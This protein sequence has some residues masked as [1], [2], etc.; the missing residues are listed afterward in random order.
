MSDLRSRPQG[1]IAGPD[2]R[3]GR[4]PLALDP[5]SESVLRGISDLPEAGAAHTARPGAEP[6]ALHAAARAGQ[7]QG[8]VFDDAPT[9]SAPEEPAFASDPGRWRVD[10]HARDAEDDAHYSF[11][12][13]PRFDTEPPRSEAPRPERPL[14]DAQSAPHGSSAPEGQEIPIDFGFDK[15]HPLLRIPFTLEIGGARFEGEAASITQLVLRTGPQAL[16]EGVRGEAVMHVPFK[17]FSVLLR[18]DV[19]AGPPRADGTQHVH[20]LDPAG[21]HVAQ[22]RYVLNSY[23]AG[24]VTS[25]GGLLSHTGSTT[26][27]KPTPAAASGG[28]RRRSWAVIALSAVMALAAAAAVFTRYTTGHEMHPVFLDQAGQQM[29]A[30]VAGQIAYL[31]PEAGPG[32]VLF[33]I[34]SNAGDMLNF[35]MPCD[36]EITLQPGMAEGT[37]VLPADRIATLVAPGAPL[38]IE[39]MMSVEGLS[40]ALGGDAVWLDIDDGRS[41]RAEVVPGDATRAAT[42]GGDSFVPVVLRPQAGALG[43]EDAGR[44]ARLRLTPDLPALLG[45]DGKGAT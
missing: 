13:P 2:R 43:P 35:Q 28:R 12:P 40:R 22:L 36:C 18:P 21:A 24:D 38:R 10:P 5:G 45:L 19:I 44:T 34:G 7:T 4:R 42:L 15:E 3:P 9:R 32:E 11:A 37:T 25:L 1:P 8:G 20:F 16:P 31:D 29:R 26:P 6:L 33:T 17:G 14:G 23:I 30:T 39:A 27:A 41:V